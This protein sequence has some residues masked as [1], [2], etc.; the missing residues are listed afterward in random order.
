M[1]FTF[2]FKYKKLICN[3]LIFALIFYLL[4]NS[5]ILMESINKSID[6]FVSKLIPALFPYLII[7]E[8]LMNSNK[9]YE[10][11]YG[12][13][14]TLSKIF[15]IPEHTTSIIIIGFLLGY[16]N[17]AKCILKM[18]NEGKI[19]K[20][21]ATKLAAFT[22]NANPSY[23]LTT[24]GIGIFKSIEI[25]ILLT[26]CHFVSAVIIGIFF[27][28]S[29]NNNIIQQ[30]NT[31]SNSFTKISSPFE[32][33]SASILSSLKTLAY[34]F[35][36]TVI[37]SLIPTILFNSLNTPDI[38]KAITIGIFEISNGINNVQLLD[39]TLNT[40]I[41]LTSFILSFSSLMILVQIF[42]FISKAT[43][44]FKDLLKYKL[45][46]GGISCVI[47]YITLKYVY[48]PT[49]SAFTNIDNVKNN[50][51]TISPFTYMLL[52]LT[53][54]LLSFIIFGKKRQVKPVA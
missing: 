46:Q 44:S 2:Y 9:I 41:I 12:I 3:I 43:V 51:Y 19:D 25:G 24:V 48:T 16:P 34:I 23:I 4:F 38:L 54:I 52:L 53:N 39:N 47:S 22:S 26:I 32:L 11:S 45:L 17:A 49:V 1:K 31:N 6:I 40:K 20:K 27:T 10:L 35:A 28:P 36:F 13:R 18:Y 7:T 29:Y 30:I 5:N 21:L 50:F 15:R 8:L 37:F 33:L 14:F 42:T